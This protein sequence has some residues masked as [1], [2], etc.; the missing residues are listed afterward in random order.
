MQI[1]ASKEDDRSFLWR[2]RLLDRLFRKIKQRLAGRK[3]CFLK[4]IL[5]LFVKDNLV[6]RFDF[7]IPYTV[8]IGKAASS[9]IQSGSK[10]HIIFFP[11]F[12]DRIKVLPVHKKTHVLPFFLLV[13]FI[14]LSWK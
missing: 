2:V 11:D 12:H 5:R 10:D 13:Y 14:Y 8:R 3:Q 1:A 4:R 6:Y 7:P 9:F